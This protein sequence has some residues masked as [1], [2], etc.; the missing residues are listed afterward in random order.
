MSFLAQVSLQ[1]N[2]GSD[3]GCDNGASLGDWTV[4]SRNANVLLGKIGRRAR[5]PYSTTSALCCQ[6]EMNS[7]TSL[8]MF[9]IYFEY[10]SKSVTIP[11]KPHPFT[12]SISP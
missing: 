1:T 10:I 9:V 2:A 5:S 4:K 12:A 7:Q 8:T 11:D 3:G 6:V